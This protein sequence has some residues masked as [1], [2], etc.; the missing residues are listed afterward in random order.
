MKSNVTFL[1][2]TPDTVNE[3]DWVN[4]YRRRTGHVEGPMPEGK[5]RMFESMPVRSIIQRRRGATV[6]TLTKVTGGRPWLDMETGN[7]YTN[8][9]VALGGYHA[10]Q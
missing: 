5:A 8:S 7:R 3:R 6:E 4:A 9:G 2:G 1:D 10:A